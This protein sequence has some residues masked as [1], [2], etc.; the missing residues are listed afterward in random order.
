[1]ETGAIVKVA[2]SAAPYHIDKPYDYLV[3][4]ELEDQAVP[5]VRVTVPFGRGNKPSEGLILARGE[6]KKVRG[7][8]ALSAV[9]DREP[10]L[11]GSELALALWMR[12]RYFCT[13][14]EAARTM[15]P[16]GLWY[17]L[18]EIWR[19]QAELAPETARAAASGI[20]HGT[21][22]LETLEDS[23]GSAGMEALRDAHGDEAVP[24]LRAL[25]K[26]GIVWHETAARQ[27]VTDKTRRMAE[28][29]LGAEEALALTGVKR[30]ASPVRYEVVK[31]L[32][33]NGPT[34]CSEITYFTGASTRVLRGMEKAGLLVFSEMEELRIPAP[35][36][37]KPGPPI[38]LSEEQQAAFHMLAELS[39]AGAASGALL[40]GVTGSGK[41]QV[42][43]RLVQEILSKGKTAI[44]L[45]PEI[46]LTPQMMEKFSSYF[47]DGVAMLHSGLRLTERYDQWKRIRR[48]EV[49]VVL[50]T[51]SAIFAPL[52]NLGVIILDEEQ[53]D[54]YRSE[55]PPR[56][57][58]RDV[59]K[60]LCARDGALLVLGSATPSVETAWAAGTVSQ[61][62]ASPPV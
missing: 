41:T 39:E 28:L 14:F 21:E 11:D 37:V 25:E 34:A 13:M 50:G 6:G 57:H 35:A 9:L 32:A 33:A 1:M 47:A 42:Y 52:R 16:A 18:Q 59:A 27:K 60:Y 26:A 40:R 8:K 24:A 2:V 30:R 7:L 58:T 53:E 17:R 23:G 31:L 12:Q 44:V 56:Y 38:V 49:R 51:R 29:A 5:G 15:L 4:A 3:P 45:V 43:L 62:G 61:G 20:R 54:S 22:I 48:G 55:N 46:V 36:V 19:L 10:V